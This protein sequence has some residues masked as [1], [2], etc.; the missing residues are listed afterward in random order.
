MNTRDEVND[1]LFA[2][3]QLLRVHVLPT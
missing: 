1:V 3:R 2:T